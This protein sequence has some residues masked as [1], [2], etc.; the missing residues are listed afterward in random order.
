[1]KSL[2]YLLISLSAIFA[3]NEVFACWDTWY[4]PSG[5]YM[6][7]VCENVTAPKMEIGKIFPEIEANCI[8]WQKLSSKTIPLADIYKVIYTMPLKELK[9]IYDNRISKYDNKFI[10]W[11]SQKDRALFDCILLAK[12]NEYIRVKH[13][14]RWYY[15]TM[16]I[17]ID[18]TL[19]EVANIAL[20]AKDS[21]LRDRYLLQAVRALFSMTRYE[22]CVALWEKEASKLPTNNLMR[23]LIQRYIAG[24]EF[25]LNR[26][27][28][29]M[30]YFAHISDVQSLCYC[31]EKLGLQ[32]AKDSVLDM[33]CQYAPNSPYV[34]QTLQEYVREIEPEGYIWVDCESEYEKERKELRYERVEWLRPFCLKMARNSEVENPAM[35]Y[36]TAAF[37]SDLVGE[38]TTASYQLS[39]A[40]R[41]KSTEYIRESIR[42]FRIYL[43][44]KLS[45]YDAAY[46]AKLFK[47]I[48]WLDSKIAN[49]IDDN[50]RKE[51]YQGYKL[52]AGESFYYWNDMLRRILLAEVCPRMLKI[53][54][55]T[56]ALQ[57][58]NMAD[59]R[60]LNLVNRREVHGWVEV[61]E[62]NEYLATETSTLREYRYSD[63]FNS[64]DYSNHFFEMADGLDA[65]SV[66]RYAQNVNNP[67][68]EFD[69]YLN[70]RGYTG[71]D[72]LNDIVGTHC[73]REMRYGEAVKYLANVSKVYNKRHL[74]VIMQYN[75]FSTTR[76]DV[77]A[78]FD[79][80][81][82]FAREM[83]SLEQTIKVEKD[84]NLKAQ[85]MF[86]YAIGLRNSFDR[87]WSLTQYYC[88]ESFWGCVI[89]DKRDWKSDKYTTAAKEKSNQYVE[90]ACRTATEKEVAANI[91]Y[92]LCNFKTVAEKYPN[93]EKGT[94]VRGKCDRLIDYHL[95]RIEYEM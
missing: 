39:L 83:Y 49:N 47:Q 38:T 26:T 13:N 62:G 20:A 35:W 11:L 21:R 73:L 54:K 25:R 88:G 4:D 95:I 77:D 72:Y 67:T 1:M 36:Y 52:N 2:K 9:E 28:K 34:S 51:V 17:G 89:G 76:E 66:K 79:S 41:A 16:N 37:L 58:A 57:L 24:A 43:D 5:Y 68:S 91:Q 12:T 59:N 64:I 86:K 23:K 75:P 71:K 22:E 92:E 70:A 84:P 18:T 32:T 93:T 15:P 30:E 8:G 27:D 3:T 31:A 6:Y 40:E 69:R 55:T 78:N 48:K 14:S 81:Y 65:N 87:C 82:K 42:V 53:G 33:V 80:R 46:E 61:E 19:E 63:N 94:L 7:R 44:A 90:L 50:V 74:N 56:R 85:K 45:K 29:A 60:L 10:E